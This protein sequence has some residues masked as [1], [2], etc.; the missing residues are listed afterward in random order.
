[1]NDM[2]LMAEDGF[3]PGPEVYRAWADNSARL[4]LNSREGA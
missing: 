3:H 1:M 2:S 4:I